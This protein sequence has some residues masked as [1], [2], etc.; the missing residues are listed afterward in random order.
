MTSPEAHGIMTQGAEEAG[1]IT[2]EATAREGRGVAA[3]QGNDRK[4]HH[5]F[6][7]ESWAL[8]MCL[9]LMELMELCGRTSTLPQQSSEG[10]RR[11]EEKREGCMELGRG[12]QLTTRLNGG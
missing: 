9:S 10:K 4:L 2:M 6:P 5:S 8:P 1:E 11:E 7:S 3:L 12:G